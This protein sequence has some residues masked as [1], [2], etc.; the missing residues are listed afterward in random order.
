MEPTVSARRT[1]FW[2]DLSI[3]NKVLVIILPLIIVPMLILAT[4]G[5]VTSSREAAK[6]AS[7]YLTQRETD[8][9]TI[10]E[11]PAIPRYFNNKAYGLTEEAEV[12]R[13]ELERSLKRFADRSNSIELIYPQVRYVDQGGNEIAKVA[14]GQIRSERG[15]VADAPFFS[16]V[17]RLGPGET[18]LSPVAARMTYAIP[19]YQPGSEGRAPIFQGA[20]VLDFV[21]P[22]QEFRRT[23]AVIA[24]TFL[25]ITALSLGIALFLTINRVRRLTDPIRRLAEAANRIAAGE[26]SVKVAIDSTDEIGRLAN[27]FNEMAT[28]LEQNEVA[29]HRKVTETQTLYEIGQEISA[30]VALGPTLQLIVE[31]ARDLLQA[32]VCLLALRQEGSDTFAI[33]AH[34]GIVPEALVGLRIRPGEGLGGRV[35]ATGLPMMAGDYSTEY[36]DS[37]FLQIVREAGIRS[38]VAV[39]LKFHAAVIGVLYVHSSVPGKFRDEDQQLLGALADQAAIAIE[40]ARLFEQVRRHAEELEAK[41]EARTRELQEANQ[42]LEDASRHKSEFLANMSHELRTPLNAIIGFTRLVMRRS[43]GVLPTKQYENLEK[44]VIS[45]DHLLG[46]INDILDLSKIEAGRMEVRLGSVDLGALVD[47][48]LRTVEPTIKSERLRLLKVM[49]PDLPT[50]WT[51]QDKLKQIVIN[52]LSNAIKFTEAGTITVTARAENGKMA[53]AVA[54]T[55]IGI[56]QDALELIFEEFRQ[57]DSSSTRKHGGTGLGLSISRHFARLLGGDIAV[58][59]TLG[60]GSTFTVTLPCHHE[61]V[62]SAARAPAAPARE[63]LATHPKDGKVIL[64]IDDDPDA[65]YLLR[66]NLTEAGYRVVGA[67]SGQEG[68][69]KARE[70][71]PFAITLDI[72]MPN[73]DGWEV[74]HELKADPATKDIPIIVVSIVDNKDLGYRLGAS[75]YLLKPFDRDAVVAALARI[76]PHHGRLLV[77]DD[78]P[79]VVDMVR[80]LLEG[81]PYQVEAAGDGQEALEA[82]SRQRP[83][84]ILLD[85]LMPRMDGFTVIEHLRQDPEHRLIPVIVLT[86]KTLTAAEHAMVEQSVLKVIQKRGLD[87]DHFIQELRGVLQA[88]RNETSRE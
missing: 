48:C 56:P 7:R 9:R 2:R 28:S 29:L 32:E 3:Q 79:Q 84:A 81:E 71:R 18:Y 88:Y 46:L 53:I 69:Q 25:I 60:V 54:D 77:V 80:Q 66:E 5:F 50:L 49:D 37:P 57:V 34:R 14:G 39:P 59:S 40:N 61:P 87:R 74:L 43:Q 78:D 58:R 42:R 26:R 22:I 67:L 11:N 33:Q 45:A 17:K 13:R 68:L 44:I 51:D 16:A 20:V 1:R 23:T 31:R 30:Q 38:A 27:S 75:D 73:K 85:L 4:V 52:L 15:H 12:S 72:M 70:L 82:I 6:T 47:G 24:S 63:D 21:Y 86:A 65:I 64:T 83:D 55:G 41:V 35:I 76:A 36:V 10:A 19:V 62:T 8:L